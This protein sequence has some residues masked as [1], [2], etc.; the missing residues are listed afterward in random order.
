MGWDGVGGCKARRRAALVGVF[1]TP[2]PHPP[3]FFA[4]TLRA[5]RA[6]QRPLALR[7]GSIKKLLRRVKLPREF[8]V[9][10]TALPPPASIPSPQ[11]QQQQSPLLPGL[12]SPAMSASSRLTWEDARVGP[13]PAP[14][15]T[16]D[17][18]ADW[19]MVFDTEFSPNM[20]IKV[21]T[22]RQLPVSGERERNEKV[23]GGLGVGRE[24]KKKRKG[25]V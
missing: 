6:K 16:V 24:M 5:D 8:A 19:L 12:H 13:Q 14:R 7:P 1:R 15:P 2:Q 9:H 21:R 3:F 18:P 25:R 22:T 4:T 17:S 10:R 20:A 11:Q 23:A